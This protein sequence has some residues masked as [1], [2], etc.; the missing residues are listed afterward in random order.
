MEGLVS[1]GL[2]RLGAA[3]S[4]GNAAC[5]AD[6]E[7]GSASRPPLSHEQREAVKRLIEEY[8]SPSLVERQLW[9]VT[10]SGKTEVYLHLAAHALGKGAGVV[11]LVPEI[12][13]TPLMIER[14]RE[15]FGDLVGVLHS[16]L[17]P[18]QRRGEYARIARGEARAVVGAR[19]AVFAPVADLRLVIIDESHDTSYKQEEAPGY[20]AR[21]VAQLR[22]EERGGLL[23][24]GSASPAVESM[25]RAEGRI[26]MMERPKGALPELEVV[27]MRQQAGEGVLAAR[28]REALAECLRRGEQAIVLLNR[29]GYSGYIHC[30]ACGHVMMCDDCELSLTYHSHGHRLLCHHCGRSYAEP[31]VCPGCGE[32]PLARGGPGTERLADEISRSAPA[33]HIFRL[34]SDVLTSGARVRSILGAFSGSHPAVLVGTQMVAKG[35]D[36]PDV[37]LVVVADADTSLYVPDFRASERTFQLLTQVSGRAGRADRP[38]RVLVQTWNPEVPC[39][40]MALD[41][42]EE[43]FYARELSIRERLGYPPFTRL[44]RLVTAGD[45]ARRVQLAAQHLAKRL[46]PHFDVQELRGPARLPSLRGKSRWHIVVSSSDGERARVI[47]AQALGQLGEPYRRRGVALSVDVDPLTFT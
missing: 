25:R 39:I 40:R 34:D 5:L 31:A 21:T 28:T 3:P 45:Q 35:H 32:A 2:V 19:S 38:G 46:S 37:T 17:T 41:R 42:D 9:G 15:R 6:P 8:E 36:F 10:G 22:L 47:V 43:A 24:E 18:A 26:R 7:K 44:I 12:A 1:K 20:H 30:E 14:V 23:L 4:E 13:L 29:R 16:G 11:L 27:D 33:G